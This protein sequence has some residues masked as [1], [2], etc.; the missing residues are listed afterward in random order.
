MYFNQILNEEAGCSSYVI[1]SRKTNEAIV[2]DPALAIDQYLQLANRR[3]FTIMMV[4]DTHIHADHI[5]GARKLAAATGAELAMHESA[6]VFFPFRGLKDGER[7]PLGQLYLDVWH[8]PGHRPELISLLITNPERGD[9]PSMVLTG[10]SLFVGD[11]GRPDFGGEEGAKQQ[12]ESVHRLLQL[13]DYVEVFPAHFEGSCGK[14]MCGRPSSTIG[15]ERRF[16]PMLGLDEAAFL[17][18]AEEPPARPLNMTAIMSTNRGEAEHFA[19]EPR[20]FDETV[21]IEA[22]GAQA[23]IEAHRPRILDVREP[24]EYEAAHI[25]GATSLP[26]ADLFGHLPQLRQD[27]ALLLVCARGVRS[28]RVAQYLMANGY[29][30]VTSLD[31]GMAGWHRARLPVVGA[32]EPVEADYQA[33]EVYFHGSH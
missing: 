28:L 4:I 22:S 18:S 20:S 15:F 7:I 29:T 2:V 24:F 26:Q 30:G 27:E 6:D 13:P 8:T 3:D 9:E 23:W 5:S 10:D 11:V 17:E 14:G 33:P 21:E 19:A 12:F 25:D 31:G 16:N 1:A 32:G